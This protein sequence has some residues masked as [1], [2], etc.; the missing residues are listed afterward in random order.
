MKYMNKNIKLCI[1]IIASFILGGALTYTILRFSPEGNITQTI[2]KNGQV[3]T[4]KNS[5]AASVEKVK[6]AVVMMQAYKGGELASTGTGFVY[7]IED[8]YAYVLTNQH[9]VNGGDEVKVVLSNDEVKDGKIMGHDEYLDLAVIRIE[10]GNNMT[11]V[12]LKESASTKEGDTIFTIGTPLGSSYR[13]SVTAGVL[14]G[15]DRLVTVSVNGMSSGDWVM[16]V[17]QMDAAV[18]P[19]NSG[20]PLFNVNG[21]VIGIISMK[22]VQE[23]IE[24]MGFAISSEIVMNHLD[25]L[26]KG[27]EIEWPVMGITMANA[28]DQAAMYRYGNTTKSSDGV[29]IASVE[30][31][32][33]AEKAGIKKGDV[34]IK[35]NGEETRNAAYLRYELYKY[36]PGDTIDVTYTR[37]GKENTTKVKLEKED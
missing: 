4:E 13:G 7:K 21:D 2:T 5:L 9:V 37:D 23:E 16:K 27:K 14:S 35:I 15:K 26:E 8:K 1:L 28:S 33:G 3:I 6:D 20:G 29:I 19:G 24:G 18:N 31:G 32:S 10:K 25:T 12:S 17:L 36:K 11:Y 30:D 22:L 34:I